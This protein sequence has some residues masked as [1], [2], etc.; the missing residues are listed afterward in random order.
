M[1]CTILNLPKFYQWSSKIDSS[2]CT[3]TSNFWENSLTDTFQHLILSDLLT[4]AIL[5]GE[6]Y[7]N[8]AWAYF[9][10]ILI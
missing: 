5:K 6:C 7:L 4:F 2:I 1:M 10:V 3:P 8:F 9:P